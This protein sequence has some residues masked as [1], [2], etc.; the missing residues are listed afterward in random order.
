M[1]K[2]KIIYFRDLR[3]KSGIVEYNCESCDEEMVMKN[4]NGY[5]YCY[6]CFSNWK[7][8][9]HENENNNCE[10]CKKPLNEANSYAYCYSCY[11]KSRKNYKEVD[12]SDF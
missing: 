12:E 3:N 6:E 5:K 7:Q 4:G 9:D 8:R 2:N 11:L 10:K 1:S